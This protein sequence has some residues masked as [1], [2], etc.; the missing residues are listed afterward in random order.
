[1]NAI[2]QPPQT[3]E[4][5]VDQYVKLRDALKKAEEAFKERTAVQREYL[6]QLDGLLLDMLNNSGGDAV[7]TAHGTVY[8]TSR[9]NASI[10]DGAAFR[11]YVTDNGLF[12]LIDF[13]ANANAVA[14]H[15]TEHGGLPPGVNYS[16]TYTVGVRRK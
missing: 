3:F 2:V 11:S 16:V 9:K 4:Q 12:D 15:I 7:K 5:V 6:K 14:D 10:C 1:M 8:R 13:R